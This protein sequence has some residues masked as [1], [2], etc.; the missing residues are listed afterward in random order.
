[1]GTV[2]TLVIIAVV[3]HA[4]L[5]DVSLYIVAVASYLMN[6]AMRPEYAQVYHAVNNNIS[7]EALRW[8]PCFSWETAHVGGRAFP[9]KDD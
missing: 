4:L 1:M 3:I 6:V 7:S 8:L 5:V 2:P 9:R